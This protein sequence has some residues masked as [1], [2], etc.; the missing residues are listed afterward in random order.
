MT[1]PTPYVWRHFAIINAAIRRTDALSVDRSWH[2]M[3]RDLKYKISC[4]ST[5]YQIPSNSSDHK[6]Q[7]R[8]HARKW[9]I[10]P[11][12]HWHG[13]ITTI[14]TPNHADN[15]GISFYT[16]ENIQ[17]EVLHLISMRV[18]HKWWYPLC[19]RRRHLDM[20]QYGRQEGSELDCRWIPI[21]HDPEHTRCKNQYNNLKISDARYK[22]T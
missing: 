8:P 7:I 17:K 18:Y 14:M 20:V 2:T 21:D 1:T 12:Y 11:F 13:D 3:A 9:R 15:I 5:W 4:K 6:A 22:E 16:L 10:C 19:A